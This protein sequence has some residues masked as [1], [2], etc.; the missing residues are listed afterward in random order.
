MSVKEID[1]SVYVPTY[2]HEKYI[3][4]ALDSILAQKTT[5]SYE[6]VIS[7]DGSTDSTMQIVN[8]YVSKY[9]DIIRAFH[10]EKNQGI[11]KNI[12]FV[13]SQCKGRYLAGLA[14][15]DY[16]INE[17]KLQKQ[18]EFLDLHKEYVAV[19]SVMELRYDDSPNAFNV[20]PPFKERNR[21]FRLKNYENGETL[22]THGFMMRNYWREE[23]GRKYF[24]RAQEI[25]AKV[26]DAVDNVLLLKKGDVYIMDLTTCV[27]RVPS[28]KANSSNYNSK[29]SRIEKTR[30]S[31]ELYNKMCAAFGDDINLKAKYTNSFSVALVAMLTNRKFKEYR[32]IYATI[33]EKYRKP[34]LNGVFV[35]SIP[36]AF[37]FA[38]TRVWIAIKSKVFK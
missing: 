23:E 5:Y 29:F 7:D 3:R 36:K 37:S 9:P 27:Y 28:D 18:A 1:I 20:L 2:F 13:R 35:A 31:I 38:A 8:E 21:V 19:G 6:I 14:G 12:F 34:F 17:E 22:Y 4:Q 26:D 33:P 16:W 30:N 32:E 11:P 24:H 15:D 10:H 25:S